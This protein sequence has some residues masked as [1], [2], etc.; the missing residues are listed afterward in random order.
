MGAL[1]SRWTARSSSNARHAE[2]RRG[3]AR[4]EARIALAAAAVLAFTVALEAADLAFPPPMGKLR[5]SSPVV[6]DRHG[7]WLRA[8]PVEDGRW[9]LRADLDRT[10]PVFVRRLLSME[11]AHFA[12]HPGVDPAALLRAAGGDLWAGRIRSGGSTLTMQLARASSPERS[13][14]PKSSPRSWFLTST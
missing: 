2:E 14:W 13:S 3:A 6:L 11:D 4:L 10:D 8:M 12:L 9:R 7:A 5:R 1:L